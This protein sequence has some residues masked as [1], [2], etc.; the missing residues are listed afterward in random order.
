MG[1]QPLCNSV[2]DGKI[3]R[4]D[5][6]VLMVKYYYDFI[7]TSDRHWGLLGS[8]WNKIQ[9]WNIDNFQKDL[10]PL[11]LGPNFHIWAFGGQNTKIGIIWVCSMIGIPLRACWKHIYGTIL[12]H[13]SLSKMQK[14]G[15]LGPNY[16]YFCVLGPKCPN[17]KIR[18][19]I[20][21]FL[22]FLKNDRC[23]RI[24]PSIRF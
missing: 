7:S 9:F 4:N 12:K 17:M 3:L 21:N 15:C 18:P 11:G 2:L 23:F 10:N 16:V 14:F 5:V 8:V 6:I 13:R 19:Q 24:V 20:P 1:R 22:Y